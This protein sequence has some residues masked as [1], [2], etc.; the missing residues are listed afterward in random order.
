LDKVIIAKNDFFFDYSRK[1][2]IEK[3]K[4]YISTLKKVTGNDLWPI[5]RFL[6]PIVKDEVFSN[7]S[8]FFFMKNIYLEDPKNEVYNKLFSDFYS[9]KY[10]DKYIF[11]FV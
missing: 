6:K 7:E 4:K 9:I 8:K 2:T 1:E 10:F 11:G 3:V 5:Y